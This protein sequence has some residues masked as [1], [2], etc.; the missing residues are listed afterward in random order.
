[1]DVLYV[2]K[3]IF[4]YSELT[5]SEVKLLIFLTTKNISW[6]ELT[7]DE[8]KFIVGGKK[9]FDTIPVMIENLKSKQLLDGDGMGICLKNNKKS[10][11][12]IPFLK[13]KDCK[14]LRQLFILYCVLNPTGIIYMNVDKFKELFGNETRL[15]NQNWKRVISNLDG[16]LDYSE[17]KGCIV[18]EYTCE[19][20]KSVTLLE[21]NDNQD[22]NSFYNKK[23]LNRTES[24]YSEK[25]PEPMITI[26]PS[27]FDC[28]E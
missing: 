12:K 15:I 2:P 21:K 25:I 9:S 10:F 13:L 5:Y 1:M 20:D 28:I 3:E 18:I 11:V 7:R 16:N 24:Y 17:K 14:S 22:K 19:N 26:D 23:L 8:K 4:D 6:C 27:I